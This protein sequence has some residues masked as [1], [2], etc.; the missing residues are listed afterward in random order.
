MSRRHVD[1][2]TSI[3]LALICLATACIHSPL[4]PSVTMAVPATPPEADF[5]G[6]PKP[7]TF[8]KVAP[9]E[10]PALLSPEGGAG[11]AGGPYLI[12]VEDVLEIS[13]YGESDLQHVDVPV[14]PDGMISFMFIGDVLAEGKTV[15]EV[16]DEMTRRLAQFLKTPQVTVIAKEFAQKK[17][18]IGG[19]VKAP[20]I[21]YLG[22][23]EGTLLDAL[24]KVGLTTDQASLDG[25]YIMRANRVVAADFKGLVRGDIT[26]NV[27]LMNQDIIYVPENV[28]R[29]VY[30]VGEVKNN[31]ALEVTAPIPI[32]QVI[33]RAGGLTMFAKRQEIAVIRGG[34]KTPEVAIINARALIEGDFSQNILVRPGDIVYVSLSALGK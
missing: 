10:N 1:L 27:R 31:T 9:E 15:E 14:R 16:R 22:G 13:I 33:T 23:K 19:E 6:P 32:I 29:Y 8:E 34:L 4:P 30:V 24:Y 28:N 11:P 20:G 12:E 7:P 26:R 25:A 2:R 17:V 3:P 5:G 18:F 21:L